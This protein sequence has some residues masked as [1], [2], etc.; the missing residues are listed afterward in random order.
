M[1]GGHRSETEPVPTPPH[2]TWGLIVL[3]TPP[4]LRA[5]TPI[6]VQVN[7]RISIYVQSQEISNASLYKNTIALLCSYNNKYFIAFF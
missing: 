6:I 4:H 7:T 3:E 2:S 1:A 5:A